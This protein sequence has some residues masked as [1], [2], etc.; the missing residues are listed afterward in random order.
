MF[1][2]MYEPETHKNEYFGEG[3]VTHAVNT[4]RIEDIY[5]MGDMACVCLVSGAKLNVT[6][7]QAIG[8]LDILGN[9]RG[10]ASNEVAGMEDDGRRYEKAKNDAANLKGG[11]AG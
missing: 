6:R 9:W 1:A 10:G 5:F 2:I 7:S 4:N 8:I 11:D 3:G